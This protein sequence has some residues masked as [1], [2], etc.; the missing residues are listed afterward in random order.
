MILAL[1]SPPFASAAV[2]PAPSS[3][4]T[5]PCTSTQAAVEPH[6]ADADRGAVLDNLLGH[7]Y[8][9]G[10]GKT[11]SLSYFLAEKPRIGRGILFGALISEPPGSRYL[12]PH[13]GKILGARSIFKPHIDRREG[14][15]WLRRIHY[16]LGFVPGGLLLMGWVAVAWLLAWLVAPGGRHEFFWLVV[17]ATIHRYPGDS[18]VGLGILA[19]GLPVY[20]LWRPAAAVPGGQP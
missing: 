15:I 19:L 11:F 18:V 7:L 17:A 10:H 9:P 8:G 16:S 12:D 1:V 14:L 6:V 20:G 13:T 3:R 4:R 2:P 5:S